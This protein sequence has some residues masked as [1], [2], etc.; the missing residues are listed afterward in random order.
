MLDHKPRLAWALTG[1]GRYLEES[2]D[3]ALEI[4]HVDLYLSKAAAE[5]VHL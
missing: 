4:P 1:S 2:L 5:V 3:I